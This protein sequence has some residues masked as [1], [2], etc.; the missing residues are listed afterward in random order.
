MQMQ[1]ILALFTTRD[2]CIFFRLWLKK[3][4]SVLQ[5]VFFQS[6][7]KCHRFGATCA[8]HG[9]EMTEAGGSSAEPFCNLFS[10]YLQHRFEATSP[11]YARLQPE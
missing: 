9:A 10:V 3:L 11:C 8:T 2:C 6:R 7:K 5:G 1:I 4:R